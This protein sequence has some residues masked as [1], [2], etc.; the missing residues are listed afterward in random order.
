MKKNMN[1]E[2]ARRIMERAHK[3]T[4][5]TV[6]AYPGTDYRATLAAALRIAWREDGKT[7]REV[8]EAMTG[9]EQYATLRGVTFA[10]YGRREARTTP[11]GDPINLFLW[12]QPDRIREDLEGV[13]SGA[14]IRMAALMDRADDVHGL[15][16]YLLAAVLREARAIDR[17]ER[18]NARALRYE[19][20]DGAARA[21]IVDHAA[22][23]ADPIAPAP[24]VYAETREALEMYARDDIDRRI[25]RGLAEQYSARE[26]APALG[27]SRQAVDKRIARI[28][29]E[30]WEDRR[31]A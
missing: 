12:V 11:A 21:Y 27:L 31:E 2:N 3:L 20:L 10:E 8:W 17:A 4:R 15:G 16:H 22:P 29:R 1:R 6:K 7:A 23:I 30:Y 18:R 26:M 19:Q 9:A 24:F 14:W 13:I 28:R 5:N 25:I